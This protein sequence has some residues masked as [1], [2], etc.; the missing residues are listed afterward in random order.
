M[1]PVVRML[2]SPIV[3]SLPLAQALGRRRSSRSF[4]C[5]ALPDDMLA[6]LLWAC[7][8][9]NAP[10]GKRTV[11]SALNLQ[12]VSTLVFDAKGVWRYR[13][14]DHALEKLS[15][16]DARA[17]TTF[18]QDFVAQAPVSIVLVADL[19]RAQGIGEQGRARCLALDAG[20]MLQSAQLA[21]CAMGLASVP[22]ASLDSTAVCRAANLPPE[23][24]EALAALTV[25]VPA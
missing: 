1:V 6:A 10:D 11:P 8:G 15:Q 3:L 12:C 22:R 20:A 21:A 13:A 4:A 17:V 7:A 19:T 25:G 16:E 9:Q 5:M 24:F 23:A 18:G 2:P 14:V